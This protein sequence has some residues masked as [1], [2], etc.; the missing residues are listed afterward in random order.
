MLQPFSYIRR[1]YN[2]FRN[3]IAFIPALYV[4]GFIIGAV[5]FRSFEQM[6][7]SQWLGQK[8]SFWLINSDDTARTVLS[9]IIGGLISLTVFSFSMV[10]IVLSQAT[11]TLSPR[12]LPQLIRD[13]SHQRVLGIYLGTTIFCFITMIGILPDESWKLPSFTIF[14][15]VLLALICMGLF[16][17]FI[18][19]ISERIQVGEVV[20]KVHR[21]A[22]K[23][24]A[25]YWTDKMEHFAVR[26]LPYDL[27]K[28]PVIL[29]P[30]SGYIDLVLYNN[31]SRLAEE[32]NTPIYLCASRSFY[33]LKGTPLIRT[34]V[35]LGKEQKE[36]FLK[37]VRLS[38]EGMSE[39]WYQP[40]IKHIVEVAVKAMSPGINDPGTALKA[41]DLTTELLAEMMQTPAFNYLKHPEGGDLYFSLLSFDKFLQA[42]MQELRQ[43][44]K[45]DPLVMRSLVSSLYHLLLR[46]PDNQ[47][48]EVITREINA[49]NEDAK[50]YLSNSLDLQS[51]QDTIDALEQER[52]V[53]A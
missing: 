24:L 51:Y 48:N 18:S 21:F 31:L 2:A 32:F 38:P 4:A 35:K 1:F 53:A 13:K 33:V 6:G 40:S 26:D 5:A 8:N 7:L 25:K 42:I 15:C 27:E 14:L 20:D 23:D 9:T 17:Y 28:W 41:I 50:K 47:Y 37:N 46:V 49:L 19:S 30:E 11:A 34:Q 43:Y 10:M 45:A 16:V 3:S 12:L 39:A 36:K 52:K 29:A 44:C 22:M